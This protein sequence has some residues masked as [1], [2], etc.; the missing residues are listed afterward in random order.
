V[1]AGQN[2]GLD[3][4]FANLVE[5][6]A[7]GTNALLG[8]LLAEG[9]LA[10]KLV[11]VEP[12]SSWRLDRRREAFGQLVLDLLDQRVAFGLGVLLGVEGV[13]E[14]VADLGL[15]LFVVGFVGTQAR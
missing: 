10:Q 11:V 4:D 14:A 6:A 2:L 12:A 7:V 1:H 9:A 8:D 15:Q 13:L 3:G 5:G